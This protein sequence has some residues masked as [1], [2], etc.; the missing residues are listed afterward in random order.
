MSTLS[1]D[2]L[3]HPRSVAVVGASNRPTSIG[4]VVTRNLVVSGYTG[5]IIPINPHERTILGLPVVN[6]ITSLTESPDLAV[7]CIPPKSILESIDDLGRQGV[8]ATIVLTAG[9]ANVLDDSGRSIQDAMLERARIHGMRL[10]GPN[11]VGVLSGS[12]GL[13]ASF[14]HVGILPGRIAFV[15]QSGAL[16]ASV[17]D[18]ALANDVGF[19][20]V[21]SLGD[22]VDIDFGDMLDYLGSDPQ[23]S[24]ILLYIESI[25]ANRAREFM[26]A[27]RGASRNKPVIAVKAGRNPEGQRAAM[28]HTGALA[29]SDRVYGAALKRAGV[30]RVFEIGELFDSAQVLA[31]A[32]TYRGKRLAIITN[33][34]GPGVLATDALAEL[35]GHV[36]TLSQET[37][38]QLDKLLPITWSR[39][40]PIDMIGDAPAERYGDA[41]RL[42]AADPGVDALLVLH[43]PTALVSTD[44]AAR[45]VARAS[46]E[47]PLPLLSCWLGQSSAD[48]GRKILQD[49]GIATLSTPEDAVGAFMHLVNFHQNQSSLMQV[50][51]SLPIEFDPDSPHVA[52][53]IRERLDSNTLVLG[54]ADSKEILSAY[55]IP[56]VETVV[57]RSEEEAVQAASR[58]GYPIALKVVSSQITHKSDVGGV[59]LNIQ[60]ETGLRTAMQEIRER[61]SRLRPDAIVDGFA[62][63]QMLRRPGA[64]ELIIGVTMDTIF[65]PT[66]LFGHGGTGVEVIGDRAVGLPPLNFK[67]AHDLIFQ[68]RIS[69]LLAGYRDRPA[70]DVHGIAKA[71]V[72]VS[73]LISD[74][75]EI[76]ELDINPLLAD[77]KGVVALD[78][79]V[80]IARCA[81]AERLA[82]RPYPK[83]LEEMVAL[84]DGRQVFVRPIRPEDQPAHERFIAGLSEDDL[85][86][87][88]FASIRK[89]ENSQMARL[90]QIDYDREMAFIA[91]ANGDRSGETIGVVRA[92]ADPD[93]QR[94]EMAVVVRSDMKARGLGFAL[95]EKII[96]YCRARGTGELVGET[97]S[98]NQPM[99]TLAAELG[100]EATTDP[101][102]GTTQLCKSLRKDKP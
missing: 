56:V 42:A 100:F 51:T 20:H 81:N 2:A 28:S 5:K 16:C 99:L 79:R 6:K 45:V 75:P 76:V 30:L 60:T 48:G 91:I 43:V 29:G 63:Q 41:I 38:A 83:E 89:L 12:V 61:V 67:L 96:R 3:L 24:A 90:T 21:V 101:E 4:H 71:L 72:C 11:C 9:L 37:I 25:G 13:N 59:A 64:H 95:M 94:A 66:I 58:I 17:L 27:A 23:T 33:G 80:R 77:D 8:R 49:A 57:A 87:R 86:S 34:G 40:N 14:A 50:P 55:S 73:Q 10:L 74:H 68:T 53:L 36:A 78:A 44:A 46:L 52:R 69:K 93:N 39:G 26:S 22:Q 47:C 32:R 62:V 98:T 88:F 35:G 82:I 19:S 54:E 92:V 85:H 7:L 15:A 1:I 70:A 65:G 97:L 84:R 31:R 18:W 102:A